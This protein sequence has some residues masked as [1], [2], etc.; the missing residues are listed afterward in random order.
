MVA[1]ATSGWHASLMTSMPVFPKKAE[2]LACRIR[3]IRPCQFGRAAARHHAISLP[4]SRGRSIR[5]FPPWPNLGDR[6]RAVMHFR[7]TST[8]FVD[9]RPSGVQKRSAARS[10]RIPANNVPN[11][12]SRTYCSHRE[13]PPGCQR[14][15]YNWPGRQVFGHFRIGGTASDRGT[16][17][18]CR[19]LYMR[20]RHLIS[21]CN[22]PM[23]G[24]F[25]IVPGFR[26]ESFPA[27][28]LSMSGQ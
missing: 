11:M 22:R 10:I 27:K 8:I 16:A 18:Q 12:H 9:T 14:A 28:R 7:Q 13:F 2:C 5:S 15:S 24:R 23:P 19:A 4:M 17:R 6:N 21:L 1:F 26:C 20:R 3:K 25:A